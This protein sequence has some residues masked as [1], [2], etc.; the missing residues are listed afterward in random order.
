[1]ADID[2]AEVSRQLRQ[3][4]RHIQPGFVPVDQRV[5]SEAVPIMPRAA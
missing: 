5:R 2:M 4:D 3:F 1:V